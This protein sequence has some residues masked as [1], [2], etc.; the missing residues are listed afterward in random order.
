MTTLLVLVLGAPNLYVYA[1][2][3]SEECHNSGERDGENEVFEEGTWHHCG[4]GN[5]KGDYVDG[6]FDGCIEEEDNSRGVCESI[7][8]R[9][10][11]HKMMKNLELN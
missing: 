4:E 8:D 1:D 9:A 7:M 5:A 6:F 2:D 11:Q 3:Y 10:I